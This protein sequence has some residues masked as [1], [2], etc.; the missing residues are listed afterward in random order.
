LTLSG[1]LGDPNG[2]GTSG[3]PGQSLSV[4]AVTTL[5]GML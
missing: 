4:S 3:M 2:N 1:N 5:A